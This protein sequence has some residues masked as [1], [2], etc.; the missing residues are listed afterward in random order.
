M[1]RTTPQRRFSR[2]FTLLEV[3]I[4]LSIGLALLGVAVL[5][6]T[7]VQDENQLRQVATDIEVAAQEALLDA[8]AQRRPVQLALDGGLAGGGEVLVLRY[9]E[10]KFRAARPGETW[11]FSPSGICEPLT[12]RVLHPLGEV[13]LSFDP[14]TGMARDRS[15]I[16]KG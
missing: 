6:L 7:S 11:E 13:E 14:L 10:H 12:L 16:V 4:A 2:G 8:V 3:T 5:A 1:L 15:V 9:G